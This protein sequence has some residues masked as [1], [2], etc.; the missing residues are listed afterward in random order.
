LSD[1]TSLNRYAYAEDNPERYNDPSG[2]MIPIYGHGVLVTT[3][4][5]TRSRL[6]RIDVERRKW[7]H[8]Y[9][10]PAGQEY[11]KQYQQ[12]LNTPPS[13]ATDQIRVL[14]SLECTGAPV[15]EGVVCWNGSPSEAG[16]V[17]VA[18]GFF[19]AGGIGVGLAFVFPPAAVLAIFGISA[20]IGASA[21][22]DQNGR[23]ANWLGATKAGVLAI[24]DT[25]SWIMEHA[26]EF[27]PDFPITEGPV[28][29]SL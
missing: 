9:K 16:A 3:A 7:E 11:W 18:T 20:G 14:A 6:P 12:W 25:I 22:I 10:S 2:H 26:G 29:P 1:P 23:N 15:P 19:L 13:Y 4:R 17:L 28:I 27:F 24:P 8:W 21:Y 5:L